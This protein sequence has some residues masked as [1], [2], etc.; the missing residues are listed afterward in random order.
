[1]SRQFAPIAQR[2]A[3]GNFIALTCDSFNQRM[4][5]A[6]TKNIRFRGLFRP[7][8]TE[9]EAGHLIKQY[10]YDEFGNFLTSL[11]AVA[12]TEEL[13]KYGFVWNDKVAITISGVTKAAL[14]VV[15][16]STAHGYIDD[17]WI[18]ITGCDMTELNGN[19]SGSIIFQVVKIDATSFSLKDV[20]GVAV[21]T[22][23]YVSVGTTGSSYKR[24]YL[25]LLYA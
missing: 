15:T 25:N 17:D 1:M 2:D 9:D 20:D 4:S 12:S 19:G 7:G 5:Y 8:V 10:I 22:S 13:A 14:G 3:M 11:T 18:E 21:D 16:T 24:T 23:A 6:G